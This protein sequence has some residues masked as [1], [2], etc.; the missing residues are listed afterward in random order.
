MLGFEGG[1]ADPEGVADLHRDVLAE[2]GQPLS[3]LLGHVIAVGLVACGDR[4]IPGVVP[5]SCCSTLAAASRISL[6]W[7]IA[8]CVSSSGELPPPPLPICT[9]VG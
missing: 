2:V 3:L 4:L 6:W 9:S 1:E 7:W 5:T 8:S